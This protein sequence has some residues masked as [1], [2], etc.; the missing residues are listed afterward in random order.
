MKIKNH[1]GINKAKITN[2]VIVHYLNLAA[3][4][5]RVW[6]KIQ[7]SKEKDTTRMKA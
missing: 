7:T 3:G 5:R 2:W 4:H 1:S 6:N